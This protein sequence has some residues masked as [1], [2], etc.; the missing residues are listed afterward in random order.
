MN[1]RL[2]IVFAA[3]L[4]LVLGFGAFTASS[5]SA[6]AGPHG[7]YN[8][9][10]PKCAACH[11]AHTAQAELLLKTS[12][13]WELCTTCHGPSGQSSLDV[14]DGL[15]TSVGQGL[16]GGGFE[17]V[18]WSWNNLGTQVPTVTA[19]VP[20]S[21]HVVEGMPVNGTPA[22]GLGTAWGAGTD[23]VGNATAI[24]PATNSGDGVT[25]TLECTSCHDPHGST[26]YRILNDSKLTHGS[27]AV[28]DV[29]ARWVPYDSGLN[30]TMDSQVEEVTGCPT[31]ASKYVPATTGLVVSGTPTNRL[32]G[33]YTSGLL[34]TGSPAVNSLIWGNGTPWAAGTPGAAAPGMNGFCGTCHR[35]YLTGSGSYN[36]P[37][38]TAI[39][40]GTPIPSYLFPGTQDALDGGGDI[41]RY[42]HLTY[43]T[44]GTS[45]LT[46]MRY[47]SVSNNA[48]ADPSTMSGADRFV[49]RSC[50][51]CHYSHGTGAAATSYAAGVAPAND[52]ALLYLD[53]RGVCQS[54]HNK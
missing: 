32:A 30:D 53:N 38:N 14:V 39:T 18:Q 13:I 22:S 10:T 19:K 41:A 3:A 50:L 29:S 42:R 9:S 16:N 23:A 26:N 47:A 54:C 45:P 17:S 21:N 11:R 6:N 44:S 51:T 28:I 4:A 27:P 31:G 36:H 33:C 46:L 52:S 25:G 43:S 24:P 8:L 40:A 15:D 20:T 12:D 5:V 7:S 48:A 37:S 35:Q 1:K 34:R 2:A 49:G